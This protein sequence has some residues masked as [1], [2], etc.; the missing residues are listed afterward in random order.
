MAESGVSLKL[1]S[2]VPSGKKK[3]HIY[4]IVRKLHNNS[5]KVT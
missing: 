4:E 3:E 1:T 5:L 2:L